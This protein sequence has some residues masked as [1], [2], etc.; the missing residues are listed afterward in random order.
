MKEIVKL[1]LEHNGETKQ[2]YIF[3]LINEVKPPQTFLK[4]FYLLKDLFKKEP[5][6]IQIVVNEKEEQK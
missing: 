5:K 3:K 1:E 6:N 2:Y 4:K